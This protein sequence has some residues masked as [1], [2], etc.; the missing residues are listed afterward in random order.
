M[1]MGY[2]LA[3]V[4]ILQTGFVLKKQI[5]HNDI[6]TK[7]DRIVVYKNQHKLFVEKDGRVVR[8]YPVSFGYQLGKKERSGD[9]KTPEGHY[10]IIGKKHRSVFTH[11]L[12]IS[13][14]NNND[15]MHAIKN[16]FHPGDAITIHGTGNDKQLKKSMVNLQNWTRG[17]I[18]M[19]DNHIQELFK[20]ISVGTPIDIYP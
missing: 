5:N 12:H 10:K 13:Y 17:C 8:H 6:N 16:G 19:H 1:I 14:P 3:T 15:K 20:N 9:G 2:I 7:P 11:S 18:G 4:I